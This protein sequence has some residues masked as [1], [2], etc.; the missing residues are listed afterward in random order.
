MIVATLLTA[1]V[2]ASISACS[3][4]SGSADSPDPVGTT[5]GTAPTTGGDPPG[6]VV[7][8]VTDPVDPAVDPA[9]P[10]TSG[11][12]AATPTTVA[13][14]P[15]IE[16]CDATIVVQISDLPSAHVGALYEL[17]GPSA[18]TDGSGTSSGPLVRPDGTVED[19]VLEIRSGGPVVDFDSSVDLLASDP[20][21]DLAVAP[22]PEIVASV[23]AGDG[24]TGVVSLT[25]VSSSMILWDPATYPTVT[26]L[27][28]LADADVEIQ[29]RPGAAVIDVLVANGTLDEGELS[30]VYF[31][32]P[33]A[34]VAAQGAI[35]QQGD[36]LVDP[37][38]LPSLPQWG[39]PV[40]FA[41]AAEAGWASYDDVVAVRTSELEAHAACLGRFVPMVQDAIAAYVSDPTATDQRIAALR[42]EINPLTR[43]DPVLLDQGVSA[44]VES[45]IF[46]V[47]P[48]GLG[49]FDQE[50]VDAVLTSLST[51]ADPSTSPVTNRFIA[52]DRT[53]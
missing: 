44:G 41:L 32:E 42:A 23:G 29:H 5:A 9:D 19:V 53:L 48:N 40:E 10:A 21:I 43:I 7:S 18:T 35:A 46:A 8:T 51:S 47:S 26:S 49:G 27:R 45:G 1:S 37:F 4:S 22:L 36:A 31:G 28:D 13:D 38:L 16:V 2:A 30:D 15:L 20:S 6:V 33:A 34:F 12:P 52:S 11:D 14:G 50:R 17:Q 25:D 3:G 24:V 39:R